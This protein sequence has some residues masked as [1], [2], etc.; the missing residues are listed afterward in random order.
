MKIF[1]SDASGELVSRPNRFIVLVKLPQGIVRAHCPNPGRLIELMNPGR[2]MIMEKSRI[3]GRKTDWTLVAAEYNGATVPLYSAKANAVAGELII[4]QLFPDAREV[5]AEYTWGKSRFDWHFYNRDKE[6]DKEIFLEVKA[7]TLIEENVAMFPDAPS[8]RASRHIEE[9]AEIA[10][11]KNREA[12]VVFVI[13]NPETEIFIPNMHTDPDFAQTLSRCKDRV[14]YHGVSASCTENGELNISRLDVPILSDKNKAVEKD[15]GVYMILLK[16][17]D[18]SITV[19]ALGE[20]VFK[21]GWYIYAGSAMKNLKSR[22]KRHL[23]KRKRKHWHIDYLAE[24]S[25]KTKAFPI[26]TL[27]DLECTMAGD[28]STLADEEVKGF[29]CS[30]CSCDSHLFYFEEDPLQNREFLKL[31][32]HYRHKLAFD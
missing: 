4:P 1:T 15:S 14:Q 26:Y 28:L 12:H 25:N 11:N 10:E 9:L 2:T 30:D 18:C 6:G 29:G 32:F 21:K 13:M 3:P 31:L 20:M 22:V 7:C 19:G 24:A 17:D 23:A 16:V 5:K 27:K 8:I